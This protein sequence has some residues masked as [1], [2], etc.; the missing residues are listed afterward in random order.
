MGFW[1]L[2]ISLEINF[3]FQSCCK[4]IDK[5]IYKYWSIK[6]LFRKCQNCHFLLFSALP[7]FFCS[8]SHN[9]VLTPASLST[10]YFV[11]KPF[12]LPSSS[13]W[14]HSL[15]NIFMPSAIFS[16]TPQALS[17][18]INSFQ[19][20]KFPPGFD[21]MRHPSQ[22]QFWLGDCTSTATSWRGFY[23][24]IFCFS[25]SHN[26]WYN[27]NHVIVFLRVLLW[28]NGKCSWN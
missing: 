26:V 11:F 10:F 25:V 8:L 2:K 3:A 16:V 24:E 17:S 7:L 5:Q 22:I 12:Q 18:S 27:C 6:C 20:R 4:C 1:S 19:K 9:W 13:P 21:Q 15:T 14:L 28:T 23:S